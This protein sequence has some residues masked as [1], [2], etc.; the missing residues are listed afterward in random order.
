MKINFGRLL[1]NKN[2]MKLLSLV[3]AVAIWLVIVIYVSPISRKTVHD[4]PVSVSQDDSDVLNSMGLFV[5][6]NETAT[7]DVKIRAERLVLS[8]V[9]ASDIDI[10][11]NL[12]GIT[13][14]GTYDVALVGGVTS[15]Y[16]RG[17]R[18]GKGF[19]LDGSDAISPGSTYPCRPG[20]ARN[21]PDCY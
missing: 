9:A 11:A 21:V 3:L 19:E 1:D 5:V 18:Y 8:S 20:G 4:V 15:N 2:L 17:D 16:N 7:V 13:A 14:P 6:D 12:S 10:V